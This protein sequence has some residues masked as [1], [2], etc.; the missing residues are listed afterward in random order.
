LTRPGQERVHTAA[1]GE[2]DAE[3][4]GLGIK[5]LEILLGRQQLF[6]LRQHT[7]EELGGFLR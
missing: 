3:A 6:S 5:S 4:P 1:E 2:A 7:P